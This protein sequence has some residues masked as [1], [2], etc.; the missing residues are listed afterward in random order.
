M[1]AGP[2]VLHDVAKVA[3]G[4]VNIASGLREQIRNDIKS[5]VDS[6]VTQLDL[7]PR[8]DLDDALAMIKTLNKK[9]ENLEGRLDNLDAKPAKKKTAAKKTATKKN[10]TTKKTS[11]KSKTKAR[12]K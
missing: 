11:A 1:S 10:S 12:K 7:V 5:R 9:V 4:A 3:G 8:E 2:K 6:M